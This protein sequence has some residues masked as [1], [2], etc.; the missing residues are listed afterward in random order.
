MDHTYFAFRPNFPKLSDLQQYDYGNQFQG[1]AGTGTYGQYGQRT[2]PFQG[3]NKNPNY[4][5]PL[6]NTSGGG[7]YNS[8]QGPYGA[9]NNNYSP[10]S[11]Q[12]FDNGQGQFDDDDI[13]NY[14]V[15]GPGPGPGPIK[16]RQPVRL[17]ARR[18][19]AS[20][21]EGLAHEP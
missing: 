15:S 11:G 19:A 9:T 4:K 21:R 17:H 14:Q 5:R 2:R 20:V 16:P 12:F 8:Y 10:Q 1:G 3:R 7:S 18:K 6:R 13:G